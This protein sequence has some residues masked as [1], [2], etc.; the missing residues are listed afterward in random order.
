MAATQENQPLSSTERYRFSDALTSLHRD[1]DALRLEDIVS[2]SGLERRHVRR[3]MR[4]QASDSHTPVE[5]VEED[6][7]IVREA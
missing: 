3:L 7:W 2:R 5:Q 4:Q 6:V 1:L